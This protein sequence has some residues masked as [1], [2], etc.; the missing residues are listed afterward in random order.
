MSLREYELLYW[1]WF[2]TMI[3][4]FNGLLINWTHPAFKSGESFIY[5][6]LW[7]FCMMELTYALLLMCSHLK[8]CRRINK[9]LFLFVCFT[10]WQAFSWAQ[11]KSL[12]WN[13]ILEMNGSCA[14]SYGIQFKMES[15]CFVVYYYI[16]SLPFCLDFT[17][18]VKMIYIVAYSGQVKTWFI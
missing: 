10:V 12:M 17:M 16:Y 9:R 5:S 4:C 1:V 13:T 6:L 14:K 18:M 7:F 8:E 3:Y 2:F 11:Q 15:L